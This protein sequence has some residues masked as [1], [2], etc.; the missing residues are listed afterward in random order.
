MAKVRLQAPLQQLQE[1]MQDGSVRSTS[2]WSYLLWHTFFEQNLWSKNSKWHSEQKLNLHLAHFHTC[3]FNFERIMQLRTF[4][5]NYFRTERIVKFW[6]YLQ[7]LIRFRFGSWSTNVHTCLTISIV[8]T[9]F[10]YSLSKYK[11][12]YK[13]LYYSLLH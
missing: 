4:L 13:Y 1:S 6:I 7:T 8:A 3:E 2:I 5:E 9:I 12:P 11:I 10:L